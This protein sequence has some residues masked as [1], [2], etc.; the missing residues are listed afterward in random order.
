MKKIEILLILCGAIFLS[1]TY[2]RAESYTLF[3]G[4]V[5]P[6]QMGKPVGRAPKR[7]LVVDLVGHT[8]TVPTQV[9]GYTLI[10][11]SEE[12]EVYTYLYNRYDLGVSSRIEW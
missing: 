7:P 10:L 12:G 8:L 11:E 5:N 6:N 1:P 3:Y 2:S 9:V 4:L